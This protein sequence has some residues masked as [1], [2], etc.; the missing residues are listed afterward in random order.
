MQR[1]SRCRAPKHRMDVR[2]EMR[3]VRH[4]DHDVARRQ[5]G[6]SF[7]PS[8]HLIVQHFDLALSA[9]ALD[10]LDAGVVGLQRVAIF[11]DRAQVQDIG[12]QLM[13]LAGRCRFCGVHKSLDPG[14]G[15]FFKDIDQVQLI[16]HLLAPRSQQGVAV[17]RAERCIGFG[18]GWLV[19]QHC[20]GSHGV[21]ARG[22][23]ALGRGAQ[24]PRD[25]GA[26]GPHI[27]PIH[28]AR[29]GHRHHHLGH[30]GHRGQSFERGQGQRRYAKHHHPGGQSGGAGGWIGHGVHEG[31]VHLGAR[32]HARA[33]K[34]VDQRHILLHI[35]Q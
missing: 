19:R 11:C 9:V 27:R 13:Q 25:V 17:V 1:V 29:V 8:Q 24:A 12:L 6:V 4:H 16:A 18:G 20:I 31:L 33:L 5:A 10:P 7:E 35:L 21:P 2:R 26:L 23:E 22:C 30:P 34:P 3:H 15:V 32:L 28:L 14:L